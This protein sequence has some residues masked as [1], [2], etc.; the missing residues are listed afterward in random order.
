[1]YTND[2]LR[3]LQANLNTTKDKRYYSTFVERVLDR[4][5]LESMYASD[6]ISRKVV[7]IPVDDMLRN[8][9]ILSSPSTKQDD[10]EAIQSA[11]DSL[12]LRQKLNEAMKWSRLYGGAVIILGLDGTGNLSDPLDFNRIR[13]GAL[14]FM[15][16]VDRHDLNVGQINDSDPKKANYREPEYYSLNGSPE[17]IHYT[18][19][20]RFGGEVLPWRLRQRN[21]YWGGSTLTRVYEAIINAQSAALAASS[22]LYETSINVMAIKGLAEQLAQPNGDAAITTRF[23]VADQMKSINNMLIIDQDTETFTRTATNFTSLPDLITKFLNTAASAADIPATRFLGDSASGLNST[24]EN[25]LKNYHD[26]ISSRQESDLRP[27][28]EYFDE[29]LVRSA[30]GYMPDDFSFEFTPLYQ[31]STTEQAAIELQDA[32]KDDIYLRSEVITPAIVADR[33]LARNVYGAITPEYVQILSEY[34][35]EPEQPKTPEPDETENPK[36]EETEA[37]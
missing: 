24:G 25:E 3:N 14:K 10:L 22:M 18:R 26:M 17:Q 13:E 35:P 8:W 2:S 36:E 15:H 4:S 12:Q 29:I 23:L 34:E 1:M 6:W 37:E 33:L 20:I 7:D 19:I 27:Q 9:R 28:L 30:I 11:E 32:Q 5:E 31:I 16:V 21:Q